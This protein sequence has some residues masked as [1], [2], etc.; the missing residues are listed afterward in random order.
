MMCARV[1]VRTPPLSKT[2][3]L[4]K[5]WEMCQLQRMK[6]KCTSFADQSKRQLKF[7][8]MNIVYSVNN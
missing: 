6:I 3:W 2:F 7:T 8:F 1:Y 5:V 4:E